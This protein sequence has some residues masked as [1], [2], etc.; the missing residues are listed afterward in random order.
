MAIPKASTIVPDPPGGKKMKTDRKLVPSAPEP[1]RS[2]PKKR[3]RLA[4]AFKRPLDK[5]LKV[6]RVP[7]ER[8]ALSQDDSAQL[9]ELKQRLLL[10]G[11]DVKKSE[12]L[13]AGLLLLSALDDAD[14]TVVV[15]KIRCAGG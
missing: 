9:V 8:Y 2:A 12:L 15:D 1:V 4:K 14:L 13:R 5:A 10:V 7:R 6:E 3:K 11:L